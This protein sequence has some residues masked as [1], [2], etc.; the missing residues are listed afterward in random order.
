MYLA[1][2]SVLL[3]TGDSVSKVFFQ[4]LALIWLGNYF[5]RPGSPLWPLRLP[6]YVP[7]NQ[8]IAPCPG[9]A[10]ASQVGK[11]VGC[12]CSILYGIS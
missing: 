4:L 12:L 3:S 8:G 9:M 1:G 2:A 6:P 10:Q 7:Q 11:K 5:L